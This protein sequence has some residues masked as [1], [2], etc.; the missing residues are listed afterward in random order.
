MSTSDLVTSTQMT[1]FAVE[2]NREGVYDLVIDR[3]QFKTTNSFNTAIQMILFGE[4][5]ADPSEVPNPLYRRGWWGNRLLDDTGFENG[6]K[7]WL[8]MQER[9][10]QE[11]LNKAVAYAREGC[12]YLVDDRHLKR[13][14]VRGEII[15]DPVMDKGIRLYFTLY[16]LDNKVES[17]WYDLWQNTDLRPLGPGATVLETFLALE[18]DSESLLLLEDGGEI[19]V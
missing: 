19:L 18:E 14:D 16:T 17:R 2:K 12:Q 1:D 8:L 3:G 15:R 7:L 6:S 4:R 10:T 11:T 13:V 9:L 5:R